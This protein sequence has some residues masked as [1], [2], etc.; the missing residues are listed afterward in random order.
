MTTFCNVAGHAIIGLLILIALLL[1]LL[2]GLAIHSICKSLA[3]ALRHSRRPRAHQ[4]RG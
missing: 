2:D 3:S 1:L 4:R